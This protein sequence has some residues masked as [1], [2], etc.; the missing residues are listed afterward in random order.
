MGD[1]RRDLTGWVT[2]ILLATSALVFY[3]LF[4]TVLWAVSLAIATF[5]LYRRA[6]RWTGH[7]NIAA[8]VTVVIVSAALAVPLAYVSVQISNEAADNAAYIAS[9]IR[10][11]S[12]RTLPLIPTS[13]RPHIQT[14]VEPLI[15]GF[16][17]F[18]QGLFGSGV[19]VVI[20]LPLLVILLFFCYR[21]GA[22]LAGRIRTLLPMPDEKAGELLR[23]VRDAT[24]AIYYGR[25]ATAV[26]QG[27]LGALMV[28]ILGVPGPLLWGAVM[29]VTSV[30]PIVGSAIVWLPISAVLMAQ[31]QWVSG[32]V[33]LGWGALV[34]SSV[35][36]LL[37]PVL[38][39]SRLQMHPAV[40]LIAIVGGVGFFGPVGVILG[41]L[42][43]AVTA[44]LLEIRRRGPEQER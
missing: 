22:D 39:G 21:D 38:I 35:D 4:S 1:S 13:V 40:L 16:T 26:V 17:A 41:P 7:P 19:S 10:S 25:L 14:A 24:E 5:P 36:N 23:A 2:L 34:I 6:N 33:L 28:W 31:G 11:L 37:F 15:G 32:L 18:V 27:L 29:V 43:I 3:P 9:G 12:E 30:L 20:K 8:A 44:K 42:L